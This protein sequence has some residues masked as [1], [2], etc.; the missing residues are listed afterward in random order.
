M[1]KSQRTI[2]DTF[3]GPGGM[4]LGFGK[5]FDVTYAI[6]N[7]P[8]AVQTYHANH[9]DTQVQQQDIRNISGARHDF[10]GI[11][12][13]IGGSPC[14]QWSRRNI[15]KKKDD[16]RA[17]LPWEYMRLVEEIRPQFFVFE[18][19]TYTPE[20]VKLKLIKIGKALGYNVV[21]Q[22]VNAA[23]YGAAQTRRRWIVIGLLNRFVEN[24]LVTPKNTEQKT[25]GSVMSHLNNNWG[26]M[27]SHPDTLE[28][29]SKAT[30][31]W[32]SL[33][34]EEGMYETIVKLQWDK[35]APAV[36]NV[37]KVYMVHPM[38]N[39]NISLAEAAALQGFPGDY[40]WHGNQRSIAQQIANAMPVEL[41]TAIAR[42]IAR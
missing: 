15:N 14:Q 1:D 27:Q 8:H 33:S 16:P 32:S 3:C 42:S 36:V 39:R 18:N 26:F 4:G 23:D 25:V 20:K 29:L 37:K 24:L 22:C 38:E 7:E 28:K 11:T 17:E 41:A 34:G 31:T 21:S 6:D 2:M 9:H 19:V 10:D 12:G 40:I 35:P 30:A 13:V 5:F